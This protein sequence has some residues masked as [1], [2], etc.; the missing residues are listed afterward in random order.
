[1]RRL[2]RGI[3]SNWCLWGRRVKGMQWVLESRFAVE[4]S[5]GRNGSP[6]VTDTFVEMKRFSHSAWAIET[7]LMKLR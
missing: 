2:L 6:V 5:N 4:T 3:G 1:M 7:A